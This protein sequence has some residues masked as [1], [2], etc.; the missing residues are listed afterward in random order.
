MIPFK[1]VNV[2]DINAAHLGIPT[3]QLME[4]AGKKIAKCA[5]SSFDI[6]GKK[7]AV[8]CGPGNNGGDGFVAAR[9]LKEDCT[10]IVFLAKSKEYI[11]SEISKA[12][13]EKI[14][15][16]LEIHNAS[17][18]EKYIEGVELIIDSVLGIG[19]SGE[20]REPYDSLI[21]KINSLGLPILSVDV[22]S[23]FGTK[24]SIWT[25]VTVTFH[26][27][28]EGMTDDNSG[29]IV[30]ED[31]G[32]PE[33]AGKYLGPGE[34]VYYPKP[35][36]ESHKGDNGRLLI[37][38]GGPYSGAPALAGLAAFRIGVDL[39]HIAT[40]KKTY[41]IIA[42]YS[43]NFIVH[44]L[45]GDVIEKEDL[46]SINSLSDK[47]ES[48]IVGP[49]IGDDPRTISAVQDFIRECPK[50]LVID[51]DAIKAVAKKPSILE[52]KPGIITP[53][54][55]EFT[56]LSGEK[57]LMDL[58][59]R[60]EQVRS[61]AK[62]LGLTILLKGEIDIISDGEYIKLNRT[63][64]PAMTV[65]GTGDVLAGLCGG[66]LSKGVT[67][68]ASARIAA[69]TN[70]TAG[71]LVFKDLGFSMMATDIIDKIPIVLNSFL[72]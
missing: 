71:D 69:F 49:G 47:V 29:E 10:V 2:L 14:K 13:F 7:V 21:S 54:A 33:D 42:S 53:H 19:I 51:A 48:I 52:G 27:I 3:A 34:F 4:N 40:P 12:N 9:H 39:V 58:E 46:G 8:I 36:I 5:L 67:P 66:M 50:P 11:R 18:I 61:L 44:K 65:G 26:D 31:I 24:S 70:G 6:R 28:K 38:G 64:N 72:R 45:S 20:L 55:G 60:G 30:V 62:K 35:K 25:N 41:K 16:E 57:I 37:I 22:P 59:E 63:G 17:E 1:E 68:F 43:P 15:G 56:I 23:G 32:I